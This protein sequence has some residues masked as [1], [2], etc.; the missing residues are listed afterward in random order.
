MTTL[1]H[2]GTE[3]V[4]NK[5]TLT[6]GS[7]A[8]IVSVGVFYSLNPSEVPEVGDFTTVQLIDGTIPDPDPLAEV[9]SIDIVTLI[10]PRNG[11]VNLTTPGDYQVWALVS[12][13][14]EDVVRKLDT[15]TVL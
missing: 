3:F 10:G 5:I 15:L 12:T 14:S 9:G 2:T 7:V 6:R 1:F 8:D 4:A 11:D 13:A